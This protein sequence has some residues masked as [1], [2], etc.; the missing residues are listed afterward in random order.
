MNVYIESI[1]NPS[2]RFK[3][4][5]YDANTKHGTLMGGFGVTFSR[6]ISKEELQLRGFKIVKSEKELP[7]TSPPKE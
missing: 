4:L 3:V 1:K 6:N 7:L 2:L 5:E